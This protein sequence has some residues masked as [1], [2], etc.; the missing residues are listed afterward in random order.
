MNFGCVLLLCLLVPLLFLL[1][2]DEWTFTFKL[3]EVEGSFKILQISDTHLG[4]GPCLGLL[5]AWPCS[6]ENTTELVHRLVQ[7]EKP[8][9]I[10]FSGDNVVGT[11]TSKAWSDLRAL[12]PERPFIMISGNHDKDGEDMSISD[13]WTRVR[14]VGMAGPTQVLVRVSGVLYQIYAFDFDWKTSWKTTSP[15]IPRAQERHYLMHGRDVPT[16]MFNHVPL[17]EHSLV[18]EVV[19]SKGEK[20]FWP[21][22]GPGHRTD[23]FWQEIRRHGATSNVRVVSVGHDHLN[24]FCGRYETTWMC[25]AGSA[26]YTAY[27]KEGFARRA[28]VFVLNTT[29]IETYKR[30]DD[31][32]L[33]DRQ[34]F[35][36]PI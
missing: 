15:P 3:F 10:I 24:D 17:R 8:D 12:L 21:W 20:V 19:G 6:E 29:H 11:E 25:Y 33:L 1:L 27:G 23:T 16:L 31:G 5:S 32:R 13:L 34:I 35:P 18:K 14:E 22:G 36:G 4:S 28:R 26:G 30:L 9:L 7:E 2:R